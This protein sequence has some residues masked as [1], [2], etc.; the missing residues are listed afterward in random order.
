LTELL[1]LEHPSRRA[2]LAK[3]TALRGEAFLL[4]RSLFHPGT[5]AYAHPQPADRG[6]VWL[7][8]DKRNLRRASWDRGELR[9]A[10]DGAVPERGQPVRCL[11]DAERRARVEAAH[12]AMHLVLSALARG[13]RVV[14]AAPPRVQAHAQF[15]LAL[16]AEGFVL[17]VL[18]EALGA[19]NGAVSRKL[20]VHVEHTT[21]DAIRHVDAQ[22]LPDGPGFPGPDDVLR[23]VRIG[24]ASALPCDGTFLTTTA[25]LGRITAPVVRRAGREVDVGFR[26]TA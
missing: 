21:R 4:D 8:G 20:E 24:E 16:R 25:G 12:T 11:L 3:V 13:S 23:I 1:Y 5:S 6:E 2:A 9:H 17:E 22:P 7:G 14:L 18:A 10:L 15:R 26:V 19:A